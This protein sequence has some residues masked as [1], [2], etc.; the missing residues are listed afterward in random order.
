MSIV[1]GALVRQGDAVLLVKQRGADD[2]APAWSVPGGVV[3]D[4]EM[5]TDALKRE[6]REE[7]GLEVLSVGS[8]E[9]V[10]NSAHEGGNTIA[11]V[12]NV[13]RW[14]GTPKPD[15]PDGLVSDCRFVSLPEA[16]RLVELLPYRM[17]REP[18]LA[19][20]KEEVEP[21]KLWQYG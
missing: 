20:L 12:F 7:A 11:I 1:V 8:I 4:G 17:M 13:M 6:V 21:G 19:Y 2:D 10:V 9:Y 15:D 16:V 3:E 5:L 18:L 14:R